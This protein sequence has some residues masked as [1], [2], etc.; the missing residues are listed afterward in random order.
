[1]SK[2]KL[3]AHR[4]KNKTKHINLT[5]NNRESR[6]SRKK[7]INVTA[8]NCINCNARKF[9]LVKILVKYSYNNRLNGC[10]VNFQPQELSDHEF[11]IFDDAAVKLENSYYVPVPKNIK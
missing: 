6:L 2:I 4:N 8:N 3:H 7:R 11:E 9:N 1:M 5:G 10:V